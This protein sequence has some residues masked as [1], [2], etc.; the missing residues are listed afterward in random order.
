[1]EADL[2]VALGNQ[3]LALSMCR[4]VDVG[5]TLIN[6]YFCNTLVFHLEA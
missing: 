1:M 4:Q 5:M 3:E 6:K 2:C